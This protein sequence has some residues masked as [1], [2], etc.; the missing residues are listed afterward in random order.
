M[1]TFKSMLKLL[2]RVKKCTVKDAE[3][4]YDGEGNP[5]ALIIKVKPYKKDACRCP[6]CGKKSPGYDTVGTRRWRAPDFNGVKVYI[7]AEQKRICCKEHG[8]A[9]PNVEWAYRGSS[10]TIEFDRI[11]GWM[12]RCI[13]K[14]DISELMRIDWATVGRCVSRVRNDLEPDLKKRLNGLVNI[15]IDET[16][17]KKGHKYITVIVNHDTNTVVWLHEGHGKS[18]LEKFYNELSDE[19]KA[20]IKVVT[21]DGARWIT[22]C[23]KEY[24][25]N[26]T[27]C[28][29]AFH[30]VE[31]ATE[32]LD[33]VRIEE[34]RKL[35]ALVPKEDRKQGRPERDDEIHNEAKK[36]K[37]EATRIKESSYAVGKAPENLTERQRETLSMIKSQTPRYYRAYDLKETLRNILKMSDS[38]E[39][40][41]ALK[42]W[43]WRA[44]HSR[45]ESFKELAK[46]IKRNEEYILNTIKYGLSNARIEA[47]NNKIKLVIRRSYGFRN[48]QN[49]LDM[50]YLCCSGLVIPLPG[51]SYPESKEVA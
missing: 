20:S 40:E 7:E 30:V 24:T 32:A 51:R 29:D 10:F 11:V 22:D 49:M 26:C 41:I 38:K 33:A 35:L 28:M 1:M 47:T 2:I 37:A 12:S 14:K 23:V 5:T 43:R 19:Q 45:I 4:E 18:V 50:I 16:S 42:K 44:S 36:R 6:V 17:Y 25:P 48:L 46:K 15:G 3:I 31:W 34:W 8:V 21:G 13:S 9:I 27:R 39:A